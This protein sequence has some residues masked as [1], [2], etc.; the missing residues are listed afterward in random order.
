MQRLL[1]QAVW[2][3]KGNLHVYVIRSYKINR[4]NKIRLKEKWSTT[5]LKSTNYFKQ[6][7]RSFPWTLNSVFLRKSSLE[8]PSGTQGFDSEETPPCLVEASIVTTIFALPIVWKAHLSSPCTR[9]ETVRGREESRHS[10]L[11]LLF[12]HCCRRLSVL[13]M[14]VQSWLERA[15]ESTLEVSFWVL[16]AFEKC[17]SHKQPQED[18]LS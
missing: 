12:F 14:H 18:S 1:K 3:V 11:A 13:A 15:H 10:D 9:E 7:Y 4:N 16:N 2:T 6:Y 5:S 17:I 8:K